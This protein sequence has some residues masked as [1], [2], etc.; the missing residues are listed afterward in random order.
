MAV[1]FFRISLKKLRE[2]VG[3]IKLPARSIFFSKCFF[4]L[5]EYQSEFFTLSELFYFSNEMVYIQIYPRMFSVCL[6]HF[7]GI[8]VFVEKW[9]MDLNYTQA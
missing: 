1:N 4:Y 5:L 8:E 9:Q 2:G 7:F 3:I 6:V